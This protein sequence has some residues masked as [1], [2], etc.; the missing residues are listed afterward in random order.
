MSEN[1]GVIVTDG[2][3][4]ISEEL[5]SKFEKEI[6]RILNDSYSRVLK[7]LTDHKQELDLIAS[8]LLL[9]K[10]LY[11]DEIKKLIDDHLEKSSS[12]SAD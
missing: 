2:D 10:T 5:K 8:E 7:T 6:T 4:K 1:I 12:R 3:D 9:K 11:G